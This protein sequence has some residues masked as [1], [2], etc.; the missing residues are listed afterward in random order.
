MFSK[1]TSLVVRFNFSGVLIYH[2]QTFNNMSI[3]ILP[4]NFPQFDESIYAGFGP[5]I[6]AFLLDFLILIIFGIALAFLQAVSQSMAILALV[7]QVIAFGFVYQILFVKLY[8]ATPGKFA[9]GIK[10]VKLDGTNVGWGEAVL[11]A[12]VDLVFMAF[13]VAIVYLSIMSMSAEAYE[14]LTLV[15]RQITIE[16]W[17]P[18]LFTI[19]KFVPLTWALSEFVVLWTNKRRRD[20]RDFIGDTL[21]IKSKY[22]KEVLEIMAD[23]NMRP[24]DTAGK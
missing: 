9:A 18:T 14:A 8:G 12:F 3:S 6:G 24:E 5:R 15:N 4:K 10:I 17:N 2:N 1:N 16:K 22:Q 19:Q 13:G 23:E 21:Q 7:I 11:R 20:L